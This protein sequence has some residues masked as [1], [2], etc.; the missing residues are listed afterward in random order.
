MSSLDPDI[1]SPAYRWTQLQFAHC[2]P[3]GPYCLAS[4]YWEPITRKTTVR[5]RGDELHATS[6]IFRRGGRVTNLSQFSN[7]TEGVFTSPSLSPAVPIESTHSSVTYIFIFQWV[8]KDFQ[9]RARNR[10]CSWRLPPL[11]IMSLLDLICL[12]IFFIVL[13]APHQN[14]PLLENKC[15]YRLLGG[16]WRRLCMFVYKVQHMHTRPRPL[17][18]MPHKHEVLSYLQ[19]SL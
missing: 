1:I 10:E 5:M 12:D 6:S 14:S 9:G 8:L 11:G 13:S 15:T 17:R 18:D 19:C 4:K 7:P 16:S 3:L 2:F